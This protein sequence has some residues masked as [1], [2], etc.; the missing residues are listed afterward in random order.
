MNIDLFLTQEKNKSCRCFFTAK[1]NLLF[2]RLKK[3]VFLLVKITRRIFLLTYRKCFKAATI[4]FLPSGDYNSESHKP[5][6]VNWAIYSN[7]Q[8]E[9]SF[10]RFHLIFPCQNHIWQGETKLNFSSPWHFD[11]KKIKSF[12]FFW[13]CFFHES[14]NINIWADGHPITFVWASWGPRPVCRN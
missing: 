7:L 3:L 10:F 6:C 5:T 1:R 9:T 13:N 2:E 11:R 12:Q 8:G 4:L 14:I